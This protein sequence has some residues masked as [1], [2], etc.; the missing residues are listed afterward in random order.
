M[1]STESENKQY[2]KRRDFTTLEAWRKARTAKLFFYSEVIPHLP[3]EEKFNL[4]IQIRKAGV[5]G[6]EDIT[7]RKVFSFTEYI[8]SINL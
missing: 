3:I 7:T 1:P 6:T 4:N 2:G 8:S 5:S